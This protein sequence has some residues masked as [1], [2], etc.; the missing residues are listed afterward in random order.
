MKRTEAHPTSPVTRL[1]DPR[2]HKNRVALREAV[3]D[4]PSD[5]DLERIAGCA[6]YNTCDWD[7]IGLL[8]SIIDECGIFIPDWHSKMSY[9]RSPAGR[10][11]I[12][13]KRR[14]EV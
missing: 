9:R 8:D 14:D 12:R 3:Y 7:E 11:S 13:R 6:W 4:S 10:T 2:L 1:A 5:A